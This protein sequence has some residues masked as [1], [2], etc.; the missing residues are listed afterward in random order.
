METTEFWET[1]GEELAAE[2]D[3]SLPEGAGM[4]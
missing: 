2:A 1:T 3:S 4:N